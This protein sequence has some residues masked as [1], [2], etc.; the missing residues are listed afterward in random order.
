MPWSVTT[1]TLQFFTQRFALLDLGHDRAQVVVDVLDG[2]LV[3]SRIGA[4]HVPVHVIAD[5]VGKLEAQLLPVL[6]GQPSSA[7]VKGAVSASRNGI[8]CSS[9]K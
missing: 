4:V 2:G 6:A 7:P 9:C 3:L 8:R 5:E 1:I